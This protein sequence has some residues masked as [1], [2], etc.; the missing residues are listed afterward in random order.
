MKTKTTCT[1]LQRKQKMRKEQQ[2]QI[3]IKT[4]NRKKTAGTPELR[5]MFFN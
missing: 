4:H 2:T 3:I 1:R 5:L